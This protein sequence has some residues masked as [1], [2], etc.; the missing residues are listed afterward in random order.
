M[1]LMLAFFFKN[2]LIVKNAFLMPAQ[3]LDLYSSDQSE[4][5][6]DLLNGWIAFNGNYDME[7]GTEKNYNLEQ[8]YQTD[9]FF[10]SNYG[11]EILIKLCIF[12][13]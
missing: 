6:W 3:L 5:D 12:W 7:S 10:K 11:I 13:F 4:W 2:P 8:K 9:S 1:L